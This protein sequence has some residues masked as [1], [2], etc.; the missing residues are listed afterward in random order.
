MVP[1]S[2]LR[3][4][5]TSFPAAPRRWTDALPGWE[6]APPRVPAVLGV[7]PGEGSGPEVI[8]AA[9][10]V[11][12]GIAAAT[13]V[14]FEV[15][16]GG[17]IG[18]AAVRECGTA[19]SADVA[20]HCRAVFAAG[21]AVLCG[22]GGGRFVYDLRR[23]FDLYCK[24]APILPVAALRNAGVLK[25]QAIDGVDVLIVRENV[26]GLYAGEWGESR[27]DGAWSAWQRIGYDRRQVERILA[28]AIALAGGRR[29]RLCVVHKPGG[30]PAISRLW[31]DVLETLPADGLD[32][33]WLEVD[34]AAYALLRDPRAFDVVVAPN[35]FGDV[36]ADA[37]ALLLGSRGV[38]CSANFGAAGRAVYQTGHGAAHDL[39]GTDRANPAGQILSLAALLRET[40]ALDAAAEAIGVALDAVLRAGWRTPDIMES[41][42]RPV[43]TRELGRRVADA[44][45][46]LLVDG[47]RGGLARAGD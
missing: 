18:E 19:L 7:L 40:F 29:R 45:Q 33:R 31:R 9:L 12:A 30:V 26:G 39:A 23:C 25:P 41:G 32:V 15:R 8:A 20:A 38:S 34:T 47:S 28:A 13:G 17:S 5:P 21:G 2:P 1:M 4:P 36:L 22:P 11:L 44:A 42:C 24:L 16:T 46:R 43:G 6:C 35:M 37:A 10:D 27:A 3:P 14:A